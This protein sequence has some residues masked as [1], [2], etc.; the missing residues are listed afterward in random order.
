MRARA[1]AALIGFGLA[2]AALGS[3]PEF[4]EFWASGAP[5]P[6]ESPRI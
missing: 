5:D 3:V 4:D 1:L 6:L 2:G